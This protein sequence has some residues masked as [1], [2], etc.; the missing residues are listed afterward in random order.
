MDEL[1]Y[2]VEIE[3]VSYIGNPISHT[4][5]FLTKKVEALLDNL[6]KVSGCLV[7]V[8]TGVVVTDDIRNQHCIVFSNRPQYEYARYVTLLYE[9][10]FEKDKQRSYSLTPEGYYIGE[11]VRIGE[12]AY[13]EPG[14]LIGHDVVIGKNV[15]IYSGAR[16][17]YAVIGDE[18]IINE[19]AIIGASGFTITDDAEGNKY[20]IPSMGQVVIGNYVE[21]GAGCNVSRGSGGNTTIED[22]VKIDALVHVAHDVYL[23]ENV[24]ITGGVI[25]G[26]YVNIEKQSF[27]GS[28]AIVKNRLDIE[29]RAMVGIGSVVMKCVSADEMVLGNP[30][31]RMK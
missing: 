12:G 25:L 13:I 10:K 14:C 6:S 9:S 3:G 20:R 28:G 31:R 26:G 21:I 11:N 24:E 1:E 8:E 23:H 5:M 15:R 22:Y 4:V 27:L 2:N 7:F 17:K 29:E 30:A 19:N 16:I 18:C